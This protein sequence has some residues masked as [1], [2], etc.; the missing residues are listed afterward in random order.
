MNQK[1]VGRLA[2]Y[3]NP[4]L[5]YKG[6]PAACIGNYECI[7]DHAIAVYLLQ[8]A[9]KEVG[10]FNVKYIIGPMNGTTWDNYRFSTH[11]HYQNFLL[12]PY[13]PLYYNQQF[14]NNG[15]SVI[16]T[17]SSSIDTTA[18]YNLSEVVKREKELISSGVTIR[19]IKTDDLENELRLLYPFISKEFSNNFLFTPISWESFRDKYIQAKNII[20]PD[21]VLIAENSQN[22]MIGFIFSYQDLFNTY[23]K[24]LIVKTVARN[25]AH[26][27]IG[28]GK[29]LGNNVVS[30]ARSRGFTSVVHAFMIEDASSTGLSNTFSGKVYKNYNLYGK[31]L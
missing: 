25:G 9:E 19:S 16:S 17:Y 23:E 10:S 1:P 8:E 21:Y 2:V 11:H 20:N 3:K 6:H 12:E 28:L 26:K 29:V 24:S 13:H 22:E 30:L 5:T 27:W 14:Q 31:K 15:Y 4:N 7:D 18:D